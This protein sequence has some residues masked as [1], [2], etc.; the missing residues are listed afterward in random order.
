MVGLGV[1]PL[2]LLKSRSKECVSLVVPTS[3]L[4]FNSFGSRRARKRRWFLVVWES[5]EREVERI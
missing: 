4:S 5:K 3:L 1:E 2:F